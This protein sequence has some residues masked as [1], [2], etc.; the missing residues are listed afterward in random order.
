[1]EREEAVFLLG[2]GS[3]VDAGLPTAVRLTTL[4][5]EALYRDHPDLLGVLQYIR[6]AVQ[7]GR[8]CRGEAPGNSVNI[9]ELLAA[10]SFL[11]N[12]E[13]SFVYP[14]V[15][16]WHEKVEKLQSLPFGGSGT[17]A[18]NSFEFLTRYCREGLRDWLAVKDPSRLKYL[19]SFSDFVKEQFRV[20]LF[21][22]NYDECLERVL[23]DTLGKI[24]GR[25]TTGFDESGWN[26]DLLDS[27]EYDAYVYK[28]H[29]SLDWVE[30]E[31][32]GVCSVK[33]PPAQDSEE[34]PDD[35]EQLLVF[36]T[37]AKLQAVDPFLTLLYRFQR[38]LRKARVLI[39]V[40]YSF[41]DSYINSMILE[42]L[43][44]DSQMRCIVANKSGLEDL[45]PQDFKRMVA[46][47]QRFVDLQLTA[48]QAL[49][50]DVLLRS[51]TE[52]I[53]TYEEE[54]PF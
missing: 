18:D 15:A 36:G 2:A 11:A 39:V 21:T 30:D 16:G 8:G 6:G 4:A 28:L 40:G 5:E 47:E 10:C 17:Q 29:G 19:R 53:K 34:I 37:D 50:S 44:R 1:M 51:L 54:F 14:F 46:V 32:F 24:N 48:Q 3:T 9:E 25:W 42:A 49:D 38:A 27:T 22:L 23:S 41:G 7:F 31:R 35:F 13:G 45:L 52:V 33:W 26:P 12:R 20:R 43:Q